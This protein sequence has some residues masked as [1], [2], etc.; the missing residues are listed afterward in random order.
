MAALSV[1]PLRCYHGSA[2]SAAIMLLRF[3]CCTLT[4]APTNADLRL[5]PSGCRPL[6][7]AVRLQPC[8]CYPFAATA[9]VVVA[10]AAA[11]AL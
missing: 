10:A 4:A 5:L 1:L 2:A 9:V 8:H 11:A 3:D 6:A 7:A